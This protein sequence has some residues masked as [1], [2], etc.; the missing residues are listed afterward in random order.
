MLTIA[1][2]FFLFYQK[3]M[4]FTIATSILFATKTGLIFFFFSFQDVESRLNHHLASLL[5]LGSL[6][7]AGHQLHVSILISQFL[8]SEW[9][10]KKYD[11]LMNFIYIMLKLNSIYLHSKSTPIQT[12]LYFAPVQPSMNLHFY[13]LD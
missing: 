6:S 9:I 4:M 5:G 1:A 7:L 12:D 13:L 11:S 2:I 3:I 10:F 8:K